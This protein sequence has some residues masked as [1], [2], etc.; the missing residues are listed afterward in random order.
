MKLPGSSSRPRRSSDSFWKGNPEKRAVTEATRKTRE[1]LIW[2]FDFALTTFFE[3]ETGLV[4]PLL[5]QG[6][7]PLDVAPGISLINVTAFNFL[8]GGNGKLPQFQELTFNIIVSPDLRRGVPR[9]AAYVVSLAS[10]SPDHLAHSAE[11]YHL[12]TYGTLSHVSIQ[13][14][15]LTVEY[16]DSRGRIVTMKNCA[17]DLSFKDSEAYIQVFSSRNDTVYVSDVTI[18]GVMCEHQERGDAGILHSHPFFGDL[19]VVHTEPE[20]YLQMISKPG[21]TGKQIYYP[22]EKLT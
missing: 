9:F 1:P 14:D 6:L 17:A 22:P 12:P 18:R 8:P 15:T 16:G 5:P 19:D 21:E 20:V 3:V 13:K 11:V 4:S 2:K 10:T 7:T